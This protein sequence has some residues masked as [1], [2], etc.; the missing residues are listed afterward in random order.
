MIDLHTH[1]TFS[2]GTMTPEELVKYA[3]KRGVEV[4]ALTDHDTVDGIDRFLS[5]ESD[6]VRVPGVEISIG[7]S[8][9]TFHLAGL[10]IDHKN[11]FLLKTLSDMQEARRVRNEELISMV[12]ELVGRELT[13]SDINTSREGEL[14]RPH[15]AA[16][17]VKEGYAQNI[18]D[19]F[20]KYLGENGQ[21]YIEKKRVDF[22]TGL[23][24]IHKAGG[25]AVLAHPLTLLVDEDKY[26]PFIKYLK[27]LGLDGIEVWCSDTPEEKFAVFEAIAKEHDMAASGGS[28]FHGDINLRVG[29]GTGRGNMNIPRSVY[30]ELKKRAAQR[31]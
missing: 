4:L 14:G 29:L 16:F 31:V 22:H 21:F 3:E 5:V 20:E 23:E 28:D 19:A 11:P 26:S 2:D 17:L 7:Y 25:I 30:E 12:S 8:P 6:V 1:S 24:A 18:N 15:I 27:G 13:E 9:G 10:F